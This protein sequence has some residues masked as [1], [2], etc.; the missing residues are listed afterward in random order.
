LK[1][2]IDLSL[3]VDYFDAGLKKIL[4]KDTCQWKSKSTNISKLKSSED[5]WVVMNYKLPADSMKQSRHTI[6]KQNPCLIN[7]L[8]KS[9]SH[10]ACLPSKAS[11]RN[12]M[13]ETETVHKVHSIIKEISATCRLCL[14]RTA[15]KSPSVGKHGRAFSNL[16]KTSES[17]VRDSFPL[18]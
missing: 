2:R 16:H 8:V 11:I 1:V 5:R 14:I 13:G 18:K 4:G 17:A 7:I 10:W 15:E 6:F 3:L 9:V 12:E